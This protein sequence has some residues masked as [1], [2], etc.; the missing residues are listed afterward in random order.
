MIAAPPDP[1]ILEYATPRQRELLELWIKHGTAEA[2]A[3][4]DREITGL[5]TDPAQLVKA[6]S[7]AQKRAVRD[8][9]QPDPDKVLVKETLT[10]TE[11]HQLKK[12]NKALRKENVELAQQ[13]VEQENTIELLQRSEPSSVKPLK[14][15]RAKTKKP[16]VAAT[17]FLSDT[18]FDE[19]VDPSQIGGV[20]SYNREIADRRLDAFVE[21]T[22][23]VSKKLFSGFEIVHL[24]LPFGGDMVSGNIH[25]E[26]A[27]TNDA[28]IMDTVDYWSE[29]L[30]QV[31]LTLAKEFP[32]VFVPCVVGNHGRN[33]R[34]PRHKGRVRD[35]FDWL[36]YTYVRRNV[37]ASGV[38]NVRFDIAEST[39]VMWETMGWTY[40][41]TH[42]DQASGGAGW[43]GIYSPIMRLNEKKVK[44]YSGRHKSFDY[45]IM[46]H[47][48]QFKDMGEVVVNGSLKG[49]DEFAHNLNFKP[50]P[51]QQAF[52]LT[53]PEHGKI[54]SGPLL[55]DD[56]EDKA[57]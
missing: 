29:R 8:G 6:K 10:I 12:Q 16:Q 22:V 15:K 34:K 53:D 41:M 56:V 45:M 42:G 24:D 50:E 51:P 3:R 11:E 31:V 49:Y 48:H 32:T 54:F 46:G 1:A 44:S 38:K 39:D 30:T 35:N 9:W 21:K 18:H 27:R 13:V 7:A 40:L 55:V 52:W 43:G 4:A 26:L 33:T 5:K 47:W 2:G 17:A 57:A 36:I 25:E 14:I 28:E 20:N 19:V 23:L 37:M